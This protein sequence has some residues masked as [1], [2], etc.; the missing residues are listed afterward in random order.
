MNKTKSKRGKA[1]ATVR[2]F[3][4]A[5]EIYKAFGLTEF[6]AE[7]VDGEQVLA[8]LK[9]EKEVQDKQQNNGG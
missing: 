6:E 2:K 7:F 5:K 1:L 8:D 9:R 3:T 4:N